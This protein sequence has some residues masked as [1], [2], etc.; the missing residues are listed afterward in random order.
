M[1]TLARFIVKF[2]VAILAVFAVITVASAFMVPRVVVNH[3]L[4]TY[5]PD[6]LQSKQGLA[7]MNAEFGE[8]T[9]FRVMTQG[10]T[11]DERVSFAEELS[12]VE[13]VADVTYNAGDDACNSGEYALYSVSAQGGTYSESAKQTDAHLKEFL[14]DSGAVYQ[15]DSPVSNADMGY[16]TPILACAVLLGITVLFVMSSSWIEPLLILANVMLAVVI[17][18]GTNAF[19]PSVSDVTYSIAAV[20]QM[21][22]SMDYAIMLM[23]RYRQE[24]LSTDDCELAM[25]NTLVKGAR[26]IASSSL[27]TIVGL[28][29]LVFMSFTIGRDL[30]IVLAKGVFLSLVCGLCIMPALGIWADGLIRKTAKKAPRPACKA[31]ATFSARHRAP[32]LAAFVI[33]I[34]VAFGVKG[35]MAASY[36]ADSRYE[37]PVAIEAVFPRDEQFVVVY[38]N[39]DEASVTQAAERIAGMEGVSSVTSYAQTLGRAYTADE[40][41]DLLAGEAGDSAGSSEGVGLDASTVNMVFYL[42]HTGRDVDS[43]SPVALLKLSRSADSMVEPDW[44]MTLPQL[45]G[46]LNDTLLVSKTVGS[47]VDDAQRE[48][49]AEFSAQLDKGMSQLVGDEYSRMIVTTPYESETDEAD[50]L[51]DAVEAEVAAA[52]DGYYLVGQ[53]AMARDMSR[54]FLDEFN[55]ISWIT[56]GAIYLIVALTFRSVLLPLPLVLVIQSAYGLVTGL[57]G[58]FD[59]AIYYM[60]I[61]VVQAILMG[62]TIDY[63]ILFTSNYREAR[64]AKAVPEALAQAYRTSTPT[65]LTSGTILVVVTLALG[66]FAGGAVAQI[67]LVLSEGSAMAMMLVL[68]LLPG[69]LAALDRFTAPRG[70]VREVGAGE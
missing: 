35:M 29:T 9:T 66:L 46:Y 25:R 16:L 30:G 64:L 61:I 11:D 40:L 21:A 31:L 52:T 65:I 57:N 54:S 58:L 26:A 69:V 62:A 48:K 15:F 7:V 22:L 8:S 1:Q 17:N 41:I 18:M 55:F 36:H 14:E 33:L 50:N 2:R 49:L 34:V 39:K 53:S 67:C 37:A 56:A 63:A 32:V 19:F 12:G 27:T 60:A 5:L 28:L 13:G 47:K 24:R 3:D 51:L 70:S 68:V 20:L 38:K 44:T 10:M 23:S 59:N 42:Y 6:S 43:M 45:V 4:T